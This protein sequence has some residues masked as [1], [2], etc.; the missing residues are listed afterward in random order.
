MESKPRSKQRL[1]LL[2]MN[3]IAV[4]VGLALGA[5][6]KSHVFQAIMNMPSMHSQFN[7]EQRSN[8]NMHLI[9]QCYSVLPRSCAVYN[10]E[11][12]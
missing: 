12:K 5:K 4:K 10:R 9:N 2:K 8:M 7:E 1:S 6:V 3:P 11:L